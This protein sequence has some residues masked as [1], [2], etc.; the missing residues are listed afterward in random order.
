[1]L[2][3]VSLEGLYF[4][5]T[6]VVNFPQITWNY[7]PQKNPQI[8]KYWI[9]NRQGSTVHESFIYSEKLCKTEAAEVKSSR[10][11]PAIAFQHS[12][13]HCVMVMD[14]WPE[15]FLV[16]GDDSITAVYSVDLSMDFC[17]LSFLAVY[18][19]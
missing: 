6:S 3:Q 1:M 17:V 7:I 10:S 9:A 19:K 15:S 8:H 16:I 12:H 2:Q 18:N 5:D 13:H 11:T 14:L 4:T